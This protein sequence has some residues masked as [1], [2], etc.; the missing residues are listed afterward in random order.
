MPKGFSLD[1]GRGPPIGL[2]VNELLTNSLK[3]AFPGGVNGPIRRCGS[4]HNPDRIVKRL[5]NVYP[6]CIG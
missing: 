4:L 1:L 3:Y 6:E 5:R 2:I